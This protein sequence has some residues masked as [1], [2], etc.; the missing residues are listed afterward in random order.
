VVNVNDFEKAFDVSQGYIAVDS[1]PGLYYQTLEKGLANG[2]MT[3][4]QVSGSLA[5]VKKF[6]LQEMESIV[7][8]YN[9]NYA[10]V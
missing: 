1:L 9:E 6:G 8:R 2:T 4:G 10:N 5:M 3:E 7:E